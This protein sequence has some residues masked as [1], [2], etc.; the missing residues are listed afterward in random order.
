MKFNTLF[1]SLFYLLFLI[2]TTLN[3]KVI[4]T[5]TDALGSVV[6]ETDAS[7][8]LIKSYHYTPYGKTIESGE[9]STPGY[10]GH[11][12]D[13]D[14]GLNYMKARYYD[15]EI[16]RFYSNDPVGFSTDNPFSFNRYAYANNNPFKFVDPDGKTPIFKWRKA[17]IGVGKGGYVRLKGEGSVYVGKNGNI[18]LSKS[19]Q[20]KVK[21]HQTYLKKNSEGTV[22]NGKTSGTGTPYENILKRD[23]Y[24]HMNEKGY[25]PAVLDKSSKNKAAIRGREQSNIE[26]SGGAKSQNGTSGNAINGIS[27]KNKNKNFYMN[28]NIKIFGK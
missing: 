2:N 21:T 28:E 19:V 13:K 22:Y 5:H 7:G 15:P 25:G 16:G 1:K 20:S 14:L 4:Y 9:N 17:E 12:Y 26:K 10:T 18:S 3:A 27:N 11:V 24:H 23:K 6:A 8:K